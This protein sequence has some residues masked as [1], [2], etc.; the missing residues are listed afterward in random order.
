[1]QLS[2]SGVWKVPAEDVYSIIVGQE[3]LEL[4]VDELVLVVNVAAVAIGGC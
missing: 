2:A 1:M 3:A 4:Q